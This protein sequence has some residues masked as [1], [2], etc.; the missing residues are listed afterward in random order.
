MGL[1]TSYSDANLVIEE[2]LT[3]TY[4]RRLISGSWSWT[5]A[6]VTGTYSYMQE[7]HRYATKSF[8]YVGMT[9]AAAKTCR[10][11][12]IKYFTRTIK[13]D[14]WDDSVM[15]GGWVT[16]NGGTILA[17]TVT[18]THDDACMYSVHVRVNEDDT[19]Y[20]SQS[21]VVTPSLEF[22]TEQQRTYG[23]DAHGTAD[24]KETVVAISTSTDETET[25]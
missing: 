13:I 11:A 9:Y 25:T 23:S 7:Y 21:A 20:T 15:G 14:V 19:H 12:M 1:I 5:S 16:K 22:A 10:D 4:S 24:E 3:V 6:N 17:A 18:L 2:G 8:R